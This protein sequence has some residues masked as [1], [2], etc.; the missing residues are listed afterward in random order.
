MN[1]NRK[2][3]AIYSLVLVIALV[4]VW[5]YRNNVQEAGTNKRVEIFG[6][7]MGTT[8]SIKYLQNEGENYK[9]AVDS[10]LELFN[11]SLSTYIPTSELSQFN[12]GTVFKF[13]LPF[14]YPVLKRSHE[15]YQETHGAFD[16]TVG[17][18]VNAWGFGP[19]NTE[20]PSKETI[21]SLMQFV[22]FDSLYFDSISVCK[23]MTGIQLDFSAIAKGY[24][25]DVVVDFMKSK[26]VA[27]MM[28]EIGGEMVCLGQNQEGKA[29]RIGIDRP[30][31]REVG[32]PLQSVV[33]LE[34]RALA[35]SGNY[36]NYY[37]KDGKKFSHTINPKTG[38]PVEHSLLSASVFAHDCMTA[39]AF[40]TAFMVIG[41]EKAKEMLNV[42][43]DLEAYLVYSDENGEIKTFISEGMKEFIEE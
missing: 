12:E 38:Y 15:I 1:P 22:K 18:L 26:G 41:L 35:T 5:W 7:T 40:A 8:Y 21:D 42:H 4:S 2:K 28:V 14:F 16:P 39:D 43:K 19:K 33:T 23:L 27:D 13:E 30:S 6:E 37:E 32:R 20:M 10:L 25:V 17:P 9:T 3:N 11:Q 36:R 31:D 34:N 29:W 24:G